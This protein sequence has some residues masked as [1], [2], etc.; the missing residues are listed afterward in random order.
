[1]CQLRYLTRSNAN[2]VFTSLTLYLQAAREHA[3]EHEMN[4]GG[5]DLADVDS[6]RN[7]RTLPWTRWWRGKAEEG[8]TVEPFQNVPA[9]PEPQS[10]IPTPP[11]EN[12]MR[13][14]DLDKQIENQPVEAVTEART[15]TIIEMEGDSEMYEDAGD[16][17]KTFVKTLRL[18]SDQLKQLNLKS[19]VNTISFTVLSS[20]SGVSKCTARIFLWEGDQQIVIS[21]IDGTITK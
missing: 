7:N 20:Y 11:L 9:S 2:G 3:A 14:L 10:P 1:M 4:E 16:R 19:G 8:E 13:E 6:K 15:E 12:S 18:T 17:R 21:D 5:N